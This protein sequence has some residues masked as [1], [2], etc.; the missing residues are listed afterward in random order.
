VWLCAIEELALCLDLVLEEGGSS[1]LCADHLS[2]AN[3]SSVAL[4]T[5]AEEC[6]KLED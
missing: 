1:A 4:C 5:G 2:S 3:L 6:T